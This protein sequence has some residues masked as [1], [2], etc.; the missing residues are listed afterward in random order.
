MVPKL[1]CAWPEILSAWDAGRGSER[2]PPGCPAWWWPGP[3][4]HLAEAGLVFHLALVVHMQDGGYNGCSQVKAQPQ[5]VYNGLWERWPQGATAPPPSLPQEQDPRAPR[6]GPLPARSPQTHLGHSRGD[7]LPPSPTN[8]QLR[9][10]GCIDQDGGDHGRWGP[11]TWNWGWGKSHP[12]PRALQGRPSTSVSTHQR[13]DWG[14]ARWGAGPGATASAPPAPLAS[15]RG[16][17]QASPGGGATPEPCRCLQHRSRSSLLRRM[18]V[19][20]EYTIAPKL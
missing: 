12:Q 4:P 8:H 20:G 3:G 7:E 5:L 16:W 19:C 1:R 2:H 15:S 18:P 11:L 17:A 13:T 14:W 9:P 10:L 6:R